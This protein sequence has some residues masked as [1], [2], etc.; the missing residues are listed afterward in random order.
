MEMNILMKEHFNRWYS[1]KSYYLATTIVELPV[2]VSL[3]Q[4]QKSVILTKIRFF[5]VCADLRLYFI[6]YCDIRDER[7][8]LRVGQVPHVFDHLA[9]RHLRS[10]EH[11]PV[12]RS[13]LQCH[14][15]HLYL[16]KCLFGFEAS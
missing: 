5:F 10:P 6:H 14:R 13:C 15:K 12:D 3:D 1:L 4:P 16:N 2:V 11:R 7:P 8:A 9:A